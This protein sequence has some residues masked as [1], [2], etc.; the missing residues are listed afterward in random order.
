MF[1]ELIPYCGRKDRALLWGDTDP[2]LS[3]HKDMDLFLGDFLRGF[4]VAPQS[5]V[6]AG[7]Y[8]PRVD[9]VDKDKEIVV[10][11]ELPGLEEKNIDISLEDDVLTIKGEK[12]QESETKENHYYRLERSHGTFHREV[13]LP[14]DTVDSEKVEASFK[15]GIL[16]IRLPKKE[17]KET[18]AKKIAIKSG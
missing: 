3:F 6:T 2:F 14:S 9:L 10:S 13:N 17:T 18:K 4:D 5:D 11:A 15:N 16:T 8:V 1:R 12:K 7:R